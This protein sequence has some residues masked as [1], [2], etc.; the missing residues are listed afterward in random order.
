[1]GQLVILAGPSCVGKGPLHAALGKFYPEVAARLRKM[2]LYNSRAPRPGEREG[3][4]YYFRTRRGGG[5][6][7]TGRLRRVR[8]AR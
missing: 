7:R 4:D 2:V 5:A 1:M 8:S 3:V 6:A